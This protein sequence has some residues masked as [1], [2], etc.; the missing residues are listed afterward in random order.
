MNADH[1]IFDQ[2]V[3]KLEEQ[4]KS[5]RAYRSCAVMALSQAKA[6]PGLAAPLLMLA[7]YAQRFVETYEGE[8][9]SAVEVDEAFETYH[10]NA[11]DLKKAFFD[12]DSGERLDALNRVAADIV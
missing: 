7:M 10:R 3:E 11:V 2:L 6:Q 4:G 1:I 9:L 12:G 8:P 5:T